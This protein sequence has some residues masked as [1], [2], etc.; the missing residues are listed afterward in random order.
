M[1]NRFADYFHELYQPSTKSLFDGR[2]LH[3][4]N[5]AYA[6]IKQTCKKDNVF[7]R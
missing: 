2:T 3:E 1:A 5:E 7:H 4:I 6:E